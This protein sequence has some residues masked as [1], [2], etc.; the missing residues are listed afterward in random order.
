M[1][2]GTR[3]AAHPRTPQSNSLFIAGAILI[4]CAGVLWSL[5]GITIRLMDD[6]EAAQIV[7]WRTLFQFV[8]FM[9]ILLA[10]HG[11]NVGAAFK[12]AGKP[13][14]LGGI[15]QATSTTCIVFAFLHTTIAD[16]VFIMSFAPFVAAI[17]A[18]VL[19]RE[20]LAP[21][22]WFAMAVGMLG[23]GVM[24]AEGLA[25][26]RLLGNLLA[27]IT[28]LG[29]A[30]LT[31]IVRWRRHVDMIPTVCWGAAI[32]S[33][34]GFVLAEGDVLVSLHDLLLCL[35]MGAFQSALGQFLYIRSSR[36]VPAGLLAFL[37]LS[38]VVLAPVWAWLGAGEVPSGFTLLGGGVLL[39]AVLSQPLYA[40]FGSRS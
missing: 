25:G 38:E 4:L 12:R 37:T 22:T 33:V 35:V 17:L 16:V 18:W 6:A 24:M 3:E 26:G 28:S 2:D 13:A 7:F 34:A 27:V 32:G 11:R 40:R 5:Q 14:V 1:S 31:V 39:G 8:T 23:V 30:G 10:S 15:C 21:H 29:F 36:Y 19:L 20:R 9:P